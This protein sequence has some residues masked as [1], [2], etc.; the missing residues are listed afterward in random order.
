MQN[1]LKTFRRIGG[2]RLKNEKVLLNAISKKEYDAKTLLQDHDKISNKIY[3]VEKGIV[4]TFYYKGGKDITYWLAAENDFVGSMSSF[5][6]QVS[7]NK[8]VETIED[9]ILWEF[10][11]NKLQSLF[12][13]NQELAKAGRLFAI[14]AISLLEQRFDHLDF[15]NASE[16]YEILMKKQPEIINRVPLNMI[17]SYLGITQETLSRVRNKAF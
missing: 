4:R 2:I 9:C 10:E 11:Y 13:A 17:A 5:F 3:F 15:N 12:E 6:L 14:Y 16:R 8:L 7:S 1:L